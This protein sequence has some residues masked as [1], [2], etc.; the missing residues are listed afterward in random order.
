MIDQD[1]YR[2]NVGIVLVNSDN[3][4]F[5]GRRA[6]TSFWQMPQGGIE[7]GETPQEAMFRELSEEVGLQPNH[8]SVI[9]RTNGW[10]HYRLPESR[11]RS[12]NGKKFVGQKQIWYLLKFIKT[13]NYININF[14]NEPEFDCWKWINFWEPLKLVARFKKTVYESALKTFYPFLDKEF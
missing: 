6:G 13:D 12:I 9:H 7:Q 1:G 4:V 14:F 2:E 8:V 3:N 5:W 10:L 11:V